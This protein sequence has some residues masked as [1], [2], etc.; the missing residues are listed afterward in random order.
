M[1][2]C[3]SCGS[4]GTITTRKE[5]HEFSI[6]V[7]QYP[8]LVIETVM[9]LPYMHCSGCDMVMMNAK[10]MR[11]QHD[12]FC[13]ALGVMTPSEVKRWVKDQPTAWRELG[14]QKK[15]LDTW[16]HARSWPMVRKDG[17]LLK[18]WKDIL[19]YV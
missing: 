12:K 8:R 17:T 19:R 14:I 10:C 1:L 18:R 7:L 16:I 15:T 9:E 4:Q 3:P 13:D 6:G 5:T 11:M 2:M